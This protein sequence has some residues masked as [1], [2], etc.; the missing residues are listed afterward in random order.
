MKDFEVTGFTKNG[1]W[2]TITVHTIRECVEQRAKEKGL[3]IITNIQEVAGRF[4]DEQRRLYEDLRLEQ[5]E[6]M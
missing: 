5:C 4:V 2:S 6:Q 1:V 3:E